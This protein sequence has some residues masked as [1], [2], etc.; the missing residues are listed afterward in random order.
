M[1]GRR[2]PL[3]GRWPPRSRKR[4]PLHGR[5]RTRQGRWLVRRC[6]ERHLVLRTSVAAVPPTDFLKIA[7]DG[8][9]LWTEEP[10]AGGIVRVEPSYLLLYRTAPQTGKRVGEN[11]KSFS[12]R[13][14]AAAF[15][16]G[17]DARA[18][19]QSRKLS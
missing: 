11:V 15:E 17:E 14:F 6:L 7:R 2:W 1:R 10:A 4:P 12:C 19:E 3:H 5:R 8:L 9:W 16:P 13:V 18:L